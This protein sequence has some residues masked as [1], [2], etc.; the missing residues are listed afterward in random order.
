M[1]AHYYDKDGVLVTETPEGKKVTIKH[2]IKAHLYPSVSTVLAPTTAQEYAKANQKR[3]I[4]A[5]LTTPRPAEI[6]EDDWF[7][8][9]I[10]AAGEASNEYIDAGNSLHAEAAHYI[11]HGEPSF[12]ASPVERRAVEEMVKRLRDP[13]SEVSFTNTE[14]GFAGTADIVTENEVYDIK[15]K[16]KGGM[17]PDYTYGLQLAAYCMGLGKPIETT[18]LVNI[19]VPRNGD[20]IE[21]VEWGT[22][23]KKTHLHSP[24]QLSIAFGCLLEAW[25]IQKQYFPRDEA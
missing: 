6:D 5:S 9:C 7:E 12:G 21:F 18:K 17:R 13:Q 8:A 4:R 3:A 2:V 14:L 25:C 1:A 16:G 20:D 15:S 10:E 24:L 11:K 23:R 19:M 22:L